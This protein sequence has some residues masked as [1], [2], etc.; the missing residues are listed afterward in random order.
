LHIIIM[1]SNLCCR[2]ALLLQKINEH[3]DQDRIF[4]ETRRI[5]GAVIQKITYEEYLP[6]LFGN[7]F[8]ELIGK[9]QGYNPKVD[10]SVFV[11]EFGCCQNAFE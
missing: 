5:I 3:W 6:R 11:S 7:K 10:P 9:Y 4:L 1:G 8:D 2:I